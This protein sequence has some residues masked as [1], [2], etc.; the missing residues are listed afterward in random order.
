MSEN[1]TLRVGD[2]VLISGNGNKPHPVTKIL[3]DKLQLDGKQWIR[4]DQAIFAYGALDAPQNE[5]KNQPR[6]S[7]DEY[8]KILAKT[9]YTFTMSDL[10]NRIYV[11]GEPLDDTLAATIRAAMRDQGHVCVNAIEDVY[12]AHAGRNSFHPVK[13][14]LKSLRWDGGEHIARVASYFT[15]RDNMFYFFF[16]RWA[17]GAIAKVFNAAQ[18][19]MLVLDGAQDAGKSFFVRWLASGLPGMHIEGPIRPDNKDDLTNLISFWIW[20]VAE[21]GSTTRRSDREALKHFLTTERVTIRAPYGHHAMTKPALASFIGTVNSEGGGILDDPTGN[22][23]FVVIDLQ[24]IDWDYVQV[25][26][27]QVWAEAFAAYTAGE[28]WRLQDDERVLSRQINERYNV[29]DPLEDMLTQLYEMNPEHPEWIMPTNNILDALHITGW[30]LQ[31]PR[32]E[33]MALA[34]ALKTM[35]VLK[36]DNKISDPVTGQQVRGYLGMRRRFNNQPTSANQPGA[37]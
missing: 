5:S 30:R 10:D 12:T 1:V 31:T 24:S 29:H 19:P 26:I 11:N 34:A 6:L 15:D 20:E 37:I 36:P 23:R 32:S 21:L 27:N 2:Y 8:I 17:I 13:D 4:L 25:D 35:P 16:R 33:A 7:S 28:E 14:Y 9:G 22:R 18:N 3:H